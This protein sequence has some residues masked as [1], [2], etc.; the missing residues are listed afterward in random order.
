M[1]DERGVWRGRTGMV[2]EVAHALFGEWLGSF[3]I[4]FAGPPPM[5]EATQRMLLEMKVP[6]PQVHF[7]RFY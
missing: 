6:M 1:E 5:A 7:D 3:E 4:Y 2:H